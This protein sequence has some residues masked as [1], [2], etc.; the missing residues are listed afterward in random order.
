MYMKKAR[1]AISIV[2][3]DQALKMERLHESSWKQ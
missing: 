1:V 2:N 3:R